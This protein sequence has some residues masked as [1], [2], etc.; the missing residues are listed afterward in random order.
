MIFFFVSPLYTD[1]HEDFDWYHQG[2]PKNAIGFS[3]ERC[4]TM[5]TELQYR[6]EWLITGVKEGIKWFLFRNHRTHT[7]YN[8]REKVCWAEKPPNRKVPEPY[9]RKQDTDKNE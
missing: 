7:K 1:P 8:K 6:S 3:K 5:I 2:V 4:Q 9:Q